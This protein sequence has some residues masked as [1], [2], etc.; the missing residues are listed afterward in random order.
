MHWIPLHTA[1]LAALVFAF[2]EKDDKIRAPKTILVLGATLAILEFAGGALRIAPL[3]LTVPATLLE[4]VFLF[5]LRWR[6]A[7]AIMGCY[8]AYFVM[9]G[10]FV[11]GAF[12]GSPGG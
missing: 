4:L 6:I 2:K 8:I 5:N 7:G 11:T 1:V 12:R 3:F 9:L 10:M